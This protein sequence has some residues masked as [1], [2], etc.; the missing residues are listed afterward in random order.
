MSPT[1]RRQSHK[2]IA[3]FD[4][5]DDA[6][7]PGSHVNVRPRAHT[8][9]KMKV[10]VHEEKDCTAKMGKCAEA[11]PVEI[12]QVYVFNIKYCSPEELVEMKKICLKHQLN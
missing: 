4:E 6:W 10:K 3:S 7:G 9:S 1:K 2:V 11:T 12:T 5:E 8:Q